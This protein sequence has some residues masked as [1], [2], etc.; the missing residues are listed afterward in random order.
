MIPFPAVLKR[1]SSWPS[2]VVTALIGWNAF[3]TVAALA[4]GRVE[5]L[6]PLLSTATAAAVVQVLALRA[7]LRVARR[8]DS[9]VRG[10]LWGAITAALLVA[11]ALAVVP[12]LAAHRVLAWLMGLYAGA[13]VGAFLSYF[14]RDDARIQAAAR[15]RGVAPARRAE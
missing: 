2:S 10:A 9:V 5:S 8:P 4:V 1:R 6:G 7:R 13:P 11:A 3:A 12:G 14:R 15:A